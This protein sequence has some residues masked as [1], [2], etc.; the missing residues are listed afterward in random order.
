MVANTMK[1]AEARIYA[2][3]AEHEIV[4]ERLPIDAWADKVTELSGDEVVHDPVE[5]LVVTLRRKGII[6]DQEA[7]RLYWDYLQEEMP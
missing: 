1:S 6:N 3:A 2:L 4:A 5:D 7:T